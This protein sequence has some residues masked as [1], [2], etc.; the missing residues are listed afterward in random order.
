MTA[1]T[2]ARVPALIASLDDYPDERAEIVFEIVS[3]LRRSGDDAAALGWL[4]T[5]TAARG[6][7]ASMARVEAADIHFEAGRADL[8]MVELDAIKNSRGRDPDA[9]SLAAELLAERGDHE[10]A[11][12]WF[13]MAASR[14]SEEDL[15]AARG[16]YGW[17]SRG[18]GILWQRHQLRERLGYPP[19][20]L[21]D[22][23]CEPPGRRTENSAFPSTD[24]AMSDPHLRDARA[25]RILT[26]PVQDFAIA[27]QRWPRLM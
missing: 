18:Y 3:E 6:L 22:G 21:E 10:G 2:S 15:A 1:T 11:L 25:I 16:E 4:H 5:L 27:K 14:L 20:D 24:E 9:Y 23:L 7:D 12:R 19:D 17:M 26:W 13:A 8:A